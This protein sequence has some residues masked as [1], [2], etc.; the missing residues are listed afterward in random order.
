MV[1]RKRTNQIDMDYLKSVAGWKSSDWWFDMATNFVLLTSDALC[2][3]Q[4]D[5][6][7]HAGPDDAGFE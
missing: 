3:P 2:H 6:M 4:L 5:V 7:A 1:Y